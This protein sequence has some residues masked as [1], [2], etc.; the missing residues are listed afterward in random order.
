M[1]KII[2]FMF[3]VIN[4][5]QIQAQLTNGNFTTEVDERLKNLNK[6]PITSNILIDR[7]F[8]VAGIPAFNQG[9]RIDTSSYVHFKQAWS[10]LYRA[11]Y[12]KNFASIS[13]FKQQLKNKNSY[14]K[15][16]PSIRSRILQHN[17]KTPI[18]KN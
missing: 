18:F 12:S 7:V 17:L 3:V 2:L 5:L 14:C 15:S 16:T 1:K 8:Q 9:T 4:S 11:S 10:E 6:A 13:Q